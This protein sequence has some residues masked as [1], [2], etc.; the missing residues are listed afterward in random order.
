MSKQGACQASRGARDARLATRTSHSVRRFETRNRR[1][2]RCERRNMK[3]YQAGG[4]ARRERQLAGGN[5]SRRV[6]SEVGVRLRISYHAGSY[7]GRI[8]RQSC[9]LRRRLGWTT[10]HGCFRRAVT[11]GLKAVRQEPRQGEAPGRLASFDSGQP[12]L[13]ETFAH[14]ACRTKTLAQ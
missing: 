8:S 7:D 3:T 10:S 9:T 4:N 11:N 6:R 5:D 14:E 1:I 12:Q 13:I 2:S